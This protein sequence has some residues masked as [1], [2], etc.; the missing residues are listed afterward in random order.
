MACLRLA[1]R[2]LSLSALT[3]SAGGCLFGSDVARAP[4]PTPTASA[5]SAAP[6]PLASGRLP[7]TARPTRYTVSL[8]VDPAHPRFSGSVVI[9]VVL[10]RPTAAIVLHASDLSVS[11]AEI[12]I[13][14]RRLAAETTLRRSGGHRDEADELVV[15]APETLPA[16]PAEL[17]LG[18]SAP[19]GERLSGLFRV[20]EEGVFHAFTQ[21]EPNDARRLLP[22][23]DEPSFKA[24]FELKVTTPKGNLVLANTPEVERVDEADGQRVTYRFAPT[25]PLPTYLFALA[26]GPFE[27]REASKSSVPIRAATPRGRAALAG[28]AL[29]AAAAHVDLLAA[30]FDRPFPYPKLDLVAVPEFGFGAMENAGL[31]SMRDDLMLLDPRTAGAEARHA[32]ASALAHEIAHHWFGN[33]V[34]MRWWDDLWLNE[35]F[36]TWIEGRILDSWRPAMGARLEARRARD[37]VMALDGLDSARAVRELSAADADAEEAFDDITYDKGAAVLGMLEA[38]LGPDA[39]RSG[40]RAYLAANEWKN[41]S[42]ADLFASLDKAG[43]REVTGVAASFLDQPGVPLVRADVACKPGEAPRVRLTQERYRKRASTTRWKI[44]ICVAFEGDRKKPA[45]GLLDG[46]SAEIPLPLAPGRCPRWIYPNAGE[47]GYYHF[48]LPLASLGALTRS[49]RSLAPP[50]RIGLI[51]NTW[52]LL[53]SGDVDAAAMIDLLAAVRADPER[54][55]IEQ[56]LATLDRVERAL[57]DE[58]HRPAFRAL[59]IKL[60][61]PTARE[62]GFDPKKGESDDKRLLRVR[63]LQ[64]LADLADDPWTIAE[65]EKRAALWL[66]DP[67]SVH[68]DVAALALRAGSRRGD[69][70]RFSALLEAAKRARSPADRIAAVSALGGF[71]DP[72]LVRRGLDL[73]VT[74]PL[75]IQDGFHVFSAALGRPASRPVVLAWVKDRFGELRGKVP[76]FALSRLT[77]VVETI[78]DARTLE[79]AAAFFG[80]ALAGLEGGERALVIALEKSEMCIDLRRR[81]ASRAGQRLDQR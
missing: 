11:R 78:C 38:W 59:V 53:H 57:V 9:A 19:I 34:T 17:H 79:D 48:A 22:C 77:S 36:A 15:A 10:P 50:E 25:P 46:D 13:G 18:W 54:R 7:D 23:F 44:P 58:A 66:A 30:Y 61:G 52:S 80:R 2:A 81:E 56:A 51:A 32:M 45:C 16:G 63:V 68:A 41:A 33:L 14:G 42:A 26:V 62:L 67:R 37:A 21:L 6:P 31:V 65:A 5:V 29:E 43:G 76:D 1:R 64:A 20:K 8:A 24:P 71:G 69:E 55:V 28:L 39:F 72:A 12:V 47:H 49:V 35:G 74:E 3:A 75:K 60:F 40:V 27:L 70:R 4:D 73:M